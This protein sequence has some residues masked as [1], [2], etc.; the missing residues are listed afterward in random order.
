MARGPR[1]G[2]GT[3]LGARAGAGL[4]PPLA[5]GMAPTAFGTVLQ[6]WSERGG[7][8]DPAVPTDRAFA[9]IAPALD[10]PVRP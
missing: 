7:A 10:A 3:P 6:R 8:E 5:A 1:G 9:V 4:S 2:A